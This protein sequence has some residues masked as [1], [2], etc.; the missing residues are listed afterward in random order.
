MKKFILL[1]VMF[2]MGCAHLNLKRENAATVDC[3]TQ[4]EEHDSLCVEALYL[5]LYRSGCRD[6][7]V[8][9]FEE[10]NITY[11][12]TEFTRTEDSDWM[13]NVFVAVPSTGTRIPRTLEPICVDPFYAL[14]IFQKS[15]D[16]PANSPDG[17]LEE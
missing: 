5:N 11:R 17:S 4:L 6:V 8:H 15:T 14:T 16:V 13:T 3:F 7:E 1:P 2:F 12:C 10:G 9:Q